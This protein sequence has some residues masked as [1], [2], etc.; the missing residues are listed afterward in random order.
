MSLNPFWINGLIIKGSIL[1]LFYLLLDIIYFTVQSNFRDTNRLEWLL[2][3]FVFI[4]WLVVL[5]CAI[6]VQSI[7]G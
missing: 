1:V 3:V 7:I 2:W 4:L 6:T 5:F